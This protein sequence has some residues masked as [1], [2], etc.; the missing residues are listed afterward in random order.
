MDRFMSIQEKYGTVDS[1][2]GEL[3]QARQNQTVADAVNKRITELEEVEKPFIV[4]MNS[5]RALAQSGI[6][7]ESRLPNSTKATERVLAMRKQLG[8][9]PQDITKGQGFNQ[10][11]RA[12]KNL[13]EQCDEVA[14]SAWN[15]H[16]KK[17]GPVVDK[18]VLDQHRDSPRHANIVDQL[19]CMLRE[20][21]TLVR[22]PPADAATLQTIE[23]QW[24]DIRRL[25]AELPI[26]DNPEVQAFLNAAV[27]VDGA[28]LDLM[29]SA[30]K[31]WLAETGMLTDFCIRRSK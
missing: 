17:T 8:D 10:L 27:S 6:V 29:T 18:K 30:V 11:C 25:L 4:A 24:E 15:D 5:I 31:Q 23:R 7:L 28:P 22:T 19:E 12:I 9:D 21:K 26:S 13:T 16:V 20:V 1:L 3:E 14:S 2:L